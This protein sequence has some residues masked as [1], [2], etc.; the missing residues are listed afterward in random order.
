MK[1]FS[2]SSDEA[3]TMVAQKYHLV[4]KILWSPGGAMRKIIIE[5]R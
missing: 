3:E 1:F 4:V 2:R 5:P